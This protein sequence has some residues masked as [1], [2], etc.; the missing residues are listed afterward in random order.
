MI[1]Y[2]SVGF[3]YLVFLSTVICSILNSKIEKKYLVAFLNFLFQIL[4]FY[5]LKKQLLSIWS[6][7][8]LNWLSIYLIQRNVKYKSTA[9]PVLVALNVFGFVFIKYQ[10]F[11]LHIF[12]WNTEVLS[13][14]GFS[15][16]TFRL[17]AMLVDFKR[18]VI[19]KIE[20]I[21]FYN[22]LTFFPTMLSGPLDRYDDF[23]QEID[24]N[25]NPD[26]SELVD[27]VLRFVIGVFKKV[28]I[29]DLLHDLSIDSLSIESLMHFSYFKILISLYMY[30]IVLYLDF[31]GYS[32]MAVGLSKI[33]GV[34]IPE[35]FNKPF[36][37]KNIQDFWNRWHISFM[38][39]LRDYI[40]Y[41]FQHLLIKKLKV[42][43]YF[44]ASILS[45]VLIF[46]LAG[47]WHGDKIQYFYYG[48]YHALCFSLYLLWRSFVQ[49]K[50]RKDSFSR[51][52]KST[53][54]Q[55]FSRFITYNYFAFSL[56]FFTGRYVVVFR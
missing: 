42:K 36:L 11:H 54:F 51:L 24:K 29:A 26:E 28:V 6:F 14:L 5:F 3:Y 17:V 35:N 25:Y 46:L 10:I 52:L 43:S 39:W 30:T 13:F 33:I 22:Y 16:F 2:T 41:P 50:K 4:F 56:L 38:I 34:K 12:R 45:T 44:L 20:L 31:S 37:A 15:F 7:L 55:I 18:N 23:C 40:Y 48:I 49:E 53:Y 9:I 1:T 32:D 27:G 21:H 19:E 8:V 47:L